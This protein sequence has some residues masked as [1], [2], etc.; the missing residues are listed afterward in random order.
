MNWAKVDKW[1]R[2]FI[3]S[4]PRSETTDGDTRKVKASGGV[5]NR[6]LME[7]EVEEKDADWGAMDASDSRD[8]C[9]YHAVNGPRFRF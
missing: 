9:G 2:S 6:G 3:I 4:E 7:V 1:K 8:G 5:W